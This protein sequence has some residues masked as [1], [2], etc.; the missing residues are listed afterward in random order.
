MTT[1]FSDLSKNI[2][3]NFINSVLI[4]DDEASYGGE[5]NTKDVVSAFAKHKKNCSIVKFDSELDSEDI[6]LMDQNSDVTILDWKLHSEEKKDDLDE[7]DLE[8][9]AES[10]DVRGK[11]TNPI[12]FNIVLN[13]L[14]EEKLKIIIIYTAENGMVQ[15]IDSIKDYL[16]ERDL[17]FESINDFTIQ[18]DKIRIAIL[19]KRNHKEHRIAEIR[20]RAYSFDELPDAISREFSYLTKGLLGNIVT[21]SICSIRAHTFKL[22][23][24]YNSE[25]FD[26]SYLA[27]RSLTEN[28]QNFIV[29]QLKETLADLM[30]YDDVEKI[31]SHDNLSYWIDD[32][33]ITSNTVEGFNVNGEVLKDVIMKGFDNAIKEHWRMQ[34]DSDISGKKLQKIRKSFQI[35]GSRFFSKKGNYDV[36]NDLGFSFITQ[37]K[38]TLNN[39]SFKPILQLGTIIQNLTR[40]NYYLCLQPKCDSVRLKEVTNILFVPMIESEDNQFDIIINHDGYK[41]FR[42]NY[43]VSDFITIPFAPTEKETISGFHKY[44]RIN[45][46]SY[47]EENKDYGSWYKW[48]TELKDNQAQRIVHAYSV[49][50]SRVGLDD[51]EW[52]RNHLSK[53]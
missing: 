44:N 17:N 6:I 19:G 12:I 3:S 43:L 14:K 51:Y 2:A 46:Y 24:L 47:C 29:D 45:F 33:N 23:N 26:G 40:G 7:K 16:N 9:D 1:N 35:D 37:N 10:D 5:F 4:A 50:L 11:Y 49:K 42:L 28:A 32:N 8:D 36:N 25:N 22:L 20:D 15:I 38:I 48:I 30:I 13:A 27:H 39:K 34:T 31:V 52:L 21:K 18:K 53:Q 41:K